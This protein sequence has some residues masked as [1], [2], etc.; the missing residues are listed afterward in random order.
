VLCLDLKTGQTVWE[1]H[2]DFSWQPHGAYPGPYATPTWYHG[3][4]YY[5]SPT[6]IV[7]CLDAA[8]GAERW[9]LNVREQFQ[10]KGYGFGYAVTP[11]VEDGRVILPVGGPTASLVA[12]DADNGRLCGQRGRIQVVTAP[13]FP[14]SSKAVGAS[15]ATWKTRY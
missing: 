1:R 15:W 10:G 5:S 14:S 7:G 3:K 6:G 8:T 9:S 2:Y 12:L 11:L 4:I 13:L